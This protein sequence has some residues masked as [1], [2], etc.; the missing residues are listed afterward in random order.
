MALFSVMRAAVAVCLLL[1]ISG[2]MAQQSSYGK[3][4]IRLVILLFAFSH[5]LLFNRFTYNT[6][7]RVVIYIVKENHIIRVLIQH[8]DDN[9]WRKTIPSVTEKSDSTFI[10]LFIFIYYDIVLIVQ[11]EI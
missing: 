6:M 2:V 9:K 4:L 3:F 11:V 8:D 1:A 10:Y 5:L 7:L